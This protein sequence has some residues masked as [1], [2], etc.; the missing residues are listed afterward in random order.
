[1]FRWQWKDASTKA[2][3]DTPQDRT[4]P[5]RE[6]VDGFGGKL[7]CYYFAFGDTDGIAICEFPDNASVAAF[8]L[9]A[10]SSG[11]FAR[12]ETTPLL[13]AEEAQSAMQRV[14]TSNVKYRPPARNPR[15]A[16][17]QYDAQHR[18]ARNTLGA[19]E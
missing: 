12:F 17:P 8:S 13:T 19:G 3:T 9:K 6:V 4:E 5:A 10:S 7:L 15:R 11:A 16:A 18:A 1:L 14:K 2:M